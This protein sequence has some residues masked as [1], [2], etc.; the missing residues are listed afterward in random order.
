MIDSFMKKLPLK[1][2]L[3]SIFFDFDNTLADWDSTD[4]KINPI[5]AKY[6]SKK[7]GVDKTAFLKCL[8]LVHHG[9]QTKVSGEKYDRFT[10]FSL[11]FKMLGKKIA[12]AQL[13]YL[14]KKYWNLV[15]KN[16]KPFSNA[17][18][19]LQQLKKKYVLVLITDSDGKTD[20][21]KY[22]KLK[23]TNVQRY[24]DLIV[25]SNKVNANKPSKKL[26]NYALKKLKLSPRE[27]IMI[28]DKPF[29]DLAPAK[30]LGMQ[31]IWM[32]KVPK[33]K[34]QILPHYNFIDKVIT[35]LR[36]IIDNK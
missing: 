30:E 21:T 12:K 13:T 2:S 23:S 31:T 33:R 35:D 29:T 34:E 5:I 10:W 3:K 9:I 26:F 6:A 32:A 11:I 28:G 1:H 4:K 36:K 24:F 8:L 14:H 25:T 27:C 7:Y 19:V 20:A 22:G 17:H 18:K 15:Y 16:L